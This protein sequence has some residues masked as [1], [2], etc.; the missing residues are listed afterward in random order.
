MKR[1]R[2]VAGELNTRA[3]QAKADGQTL[4][5]ALVVTSSEKLLARVEWYRGREKALREAAELVLQMFGGAT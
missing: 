2:E 5:A 3:R 1:E 4:L